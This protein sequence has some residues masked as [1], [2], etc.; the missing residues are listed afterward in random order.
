MTDL[1]LAFCGYEAALFACKA[2][3]YS[4]SLPASRRVCIG[5][6]E[7]GRFIGAIVF[8]RGAARHI[9]K[10]FGL[11]QSEVCELTRVALRDHVTP[12][13][14]IMAIALRLLTRQSPGLK[15]VISYSDPQHGHDGRGVYA[16]GNWLYLGLTHPEALLKVHGQC[17]HPRSIGSKFGCR[18]IEWLRT[19]VDPHAERIVTAPKHKYA[20]PFDADIR[21]HLLPLVRPYPTRP[22]VA[23]PCAIPAGLGGATPTRPLHCDEAAH[24]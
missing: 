23:G 24:A 3:H 15:L 20:F 17:R 6:W 19:H 11:R 9:G 10:P 4:R 14:R 5:V 18:D 12:T 7:D 16:A 22:K 1:H 13:S 8:S 21:A 2:F